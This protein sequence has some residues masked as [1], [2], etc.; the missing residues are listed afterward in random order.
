MI[1]DVIFNE[2]D[3]MSKDFPTLMKDSIKSAFRWDGV[4]KTNNSFAEFHCCS[5][6][7]AMYTIAFNLY[8]I[9]LEVIKMQKG[10][11]PATLVTIPMYIPDHV[12]H[13]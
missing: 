13:H 4:V 11:I 12:Y 7:K 6:C 9:L 3:I 8:P 5:N 2:T 1:V 10:T